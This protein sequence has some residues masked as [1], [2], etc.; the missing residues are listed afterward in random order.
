MWMQDVLAN[1]A[2][3]YRNGLIDYISRKDTE[4]VSKIANMDKDKALAFLD[5]ELQDATVS[6]YINA[7]RK[8]QANINDVNKILTSDDTS[9][10]YRQYRRLQGEIEARNVQD[11][12]SASQFM[13]QPEAQKLT[14]DEIRAKLHPG[15][16]EDIQ[17][18]PR[19]IIQY[20]EE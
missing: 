9:M 8:T 3:N 17:S 12:H 20:M 10:A 7:I 1:E 18:G 5:N 13:K 4:L 15:A 16:T 2:K 6:A 11:R 19:Y 14:P